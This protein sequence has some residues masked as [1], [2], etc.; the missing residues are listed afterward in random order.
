MGAESLEAVQVV[1]LDKT[2]SLL[3]LEAVVG[4]IHRNRDIRREGEGP[5]GQEA[6]PQAHWVVLEAD[7]QPL[8][9]RHKE[10]TSQIVVAGSWAATL[11]LGAE[12]QSFEGPSHLEAVV[13]ELGQNLELAEPM[14]WA[15][16]HLKVAL[17]VQTP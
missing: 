11:A 16:A 7:I 15:W 9:A 10:D 3:V 1:H 17:W 12:V 6:G 5:P 2:G 8:E 13:V 14:Q 4:D